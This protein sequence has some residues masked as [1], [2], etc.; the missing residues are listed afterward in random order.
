[1]N[2]LDYVRIVVRRGWIIVLAIILTSGAAFGLSKLQTEEYRATQKVLLLPARN[3]LGLSETLRILLRSFVEYL[4]TD[5]VAG[6]VI[7][8]LQLD[9]Q[10]GDLRSDTTI[11][12]DPTTLTIQIDVDLPD[13]P[14]AADI[15]TEWGRQLVLFRDQENSTLRQEDRIKAQL[16]DTAAYGLHRPN[17]RV[18]V[19]A[20]GILG[21]IVGAV[22]VFVLEYIESSVIR[23]A[24]DMERLLDI[25]LLA[26]VPEEN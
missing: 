25:D 22:V 11:N 5:Q 24:G 10:P 4:N 21:V 7:E 6:V 14:Q 1:M 23:D 12:S 8:E 16:L 13:G 17:T 18:N 3:D 26:V 20:G 19:I 9:I 15:A 2:L